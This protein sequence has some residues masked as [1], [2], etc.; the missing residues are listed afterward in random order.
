[1]VE[2]VLF[3]QIRHLGNLPSV[4]LAFKGAESH[5]RVKERTHS[6]SPVAL[7]SVGWRAYEEVTE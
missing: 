2:L 6:F 5:P 1:M 3:P 4:K 7:Q